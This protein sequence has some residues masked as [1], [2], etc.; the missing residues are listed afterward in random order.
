MLM[1]LAENVELWPSSDIV[2][3]FT[4]CHEDNGLLRRLHYIL[5]VMVPVHK[6][7]IHLCHLQLCSLPWRAKTMSLPSH[8]MFLPTISAVCLFKHWLFTMWKPH[9]R[10]C[11]WAQTWRSASGG[12]ELLIGDFSNLYF[13][14]EAWKYCLQDIGVTLICFSLGF[15][16]SAVLHCRRHKREKCYSSLVSIC[17]I[18]AYFDNEF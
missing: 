6:V 10:I 13:N 5:S 3:D 12:F 7:K 15:T 18:S 2:T 16:F 17:K 11:M 9:V 8:L 4:Q 1:F 14:D